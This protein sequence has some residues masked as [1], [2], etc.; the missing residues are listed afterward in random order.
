MRIRVEKRARSGV[1]FNQLKKLCYCGERLNGE[2][3]TDDGTLLL[4][5]YHP[6]M[7]DKGRNENG[8]NIRWQ[9]KTS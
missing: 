8:R 4:I 9:K 3:E 5:R 7:G 6:V 1:S 2:I